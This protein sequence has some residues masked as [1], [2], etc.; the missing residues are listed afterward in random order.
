[1]RRNLEGLLRG[2]ALVDLPGVLVELRERPQLR[3]P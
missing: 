3:L 1:M 2:I